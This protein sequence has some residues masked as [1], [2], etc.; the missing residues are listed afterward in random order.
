MIGK[1]GLTKQSLVTV[2]TP[3]IG[4]GRW[5]ALRDSELAHLLRQ[6]GNPVGGTLQQ[7]D[8]QRLSRADYAGEPPCDASSLLRRALDETGIVHFLSLN[9]IAADEEGKTSFLLLEMTVDGSHSEGI[10]AVMRTAGELLL[11]VYRVAADIRSVQALQRHLLRRRLTIYAHSPAWTLWPWGKAIGLEFKGTN[12]LSVERIKRDQE[13]YRKASELLQSLR[14]HER[15]P[16]DGIQHAETTTTLRKSQP[17]TAL[18]KLRIV[19]RQIIGTTVNPISIHIKRSVGELDFARDN[20][21][22]LSP[23]K[24]AF[25]LLWRPI[26]TMLAMFLAV[27]LIADNVPRF[28]YNL[29][30]FEPAT[31]QVFEACPDESNLQSIISAIED[32]EQKIDLLKRCGPQSTTEVELTFLGRALK[33]GMQISDG[34]FEV[35]GRALFWLVVLSGLIAS[36]FV[37]W[38]R[39]SEIENKPNDDD[40]DI[41]VVREISLRENLTRQQNHMISITKVLP[42]VL[43]R[44]VTLPLGLMLVGK[45][46]ASESER[47]GFLGGMGTIHSARFVVLPGTRKLVFLSN[48]NGSWESY[49]EDFVEKSAPGMTGIWSNCEG[50]P[51]TE[52]LTN[53]GGHDGDRFKRFARRSMVPTYLWYSAYDDMTAAQ[54]RRNALVTRGLALESSDT[55]AEAWLDLFGSVQRPDSAIEFEDAQTLAFRGHQFLPHGACQPICFPDE[56]T[57]SEIQAWVGEITKYISFGNFKLKTQAIQLS[58]SAHGLERLGIAEAVAERQQEI[59][60]KEKGFPPAFRF[61]MDHPTRRNVLGDVGRNAPDR[62]NWG[63]NAPSQSEMQG[64][65]THAVILMYASSAE[66]LTDVRA[67]IKGIWDATINSGRSDALSQEITFDPD[68]H[69]IGKKAREPFGWADGLS[70]PWIRGVSWKRKGD[71]SNTVEAGEFILGYKDN[72]GYWPPTPLIAEDRDPLDHLSHPPD[73]QPKEYPSHKSSELRDFGRNGSYLVIR[74]LEQDTVAFKAWTDE[75]AAEATDP[76]VT[77][78]L[79]GAKMF[80]RWKSGAPLVRYPD[81]DP[82]EYGENSEAPEQNDFLY[83]LEDSQGHNCPLG[84][85]IRRANPRDSLDFRNPEALSVANRHRL[86]RRGRSYRTKEGKVGTLFMC[87]NADLERQFEFVQQNW[88]NASQFH[89]LSGEVDPVTGQR[90]GVGGFSVPGPSG[91]KTLTGL[92]SFVTMKGGGYFFLPGRRAL[93][94]LAGDFASTVRPVQ[95][96]PREVLTYPTTAK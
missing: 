41:D 5:Q 65:K 4:D 64:S 12:Q 79:I 21:V 34:L 39:M 25:G 14:R 47:P 13:V 16:S 66:Q 24:Y 50:F 74:Q 48:Y 87:L 62:W 42:S 19:R 77:G 96:T 40:P 83:G 51:E 52:F 30:S 80:G 17:H 1:D 72:R 31:V 54:I 84:A 26:L 69:Q 35:L 89:A 33:F 58:F 3:I 76:R 93:N 81:H 27:I 59:H 61:G 18:E 45:S 73:Q 11:P 92:P 43:R 94:F 68:L 95:T 91:T 57:T 9:L 53:K 82:C 90:E 8:P 15:L 49:L 2:C 20:P 88:I 78:H 67:C 70:Q 55:N 37:V 22:E 10:K 56:T 60:P 23:L 7:D 38:L 28:F 71:P 85:H 6:L 32:P 29:F 46:S 86:L 63:N 75:K 44:F 36:L